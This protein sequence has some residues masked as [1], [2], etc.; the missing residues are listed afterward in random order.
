[1]SGRDWQAFDAELRARVPELAVELLGKPTFRAGQEWRWGRKGSLSVVIGGAKAGMWFDHQ[2]GRGGWFSDLVGRDLGMAREDATDWIADRIGMEALPRPAR[3]RSTPGATPAN[4]PGEP[5]TAPATAPPETIPDDDTASA[6]NRAVE[7]AVRATR[8]WSSGR[9]ALNDHPYLVAKHA[10]PLALRM[11]TSGRLV[12]PLQ[13][14]DGR[15]HSLEK[16]APDGAKRF[17]AGGAKKGHFAVVGAEPGPIA[18]PTGP[19]LICE[20]WA[21]GASLH[22]ATGHTVIAAM[23]AGNLMP[24]AEALRARFSVADLVLVAD[25]DKKPDR[26]TNPGVEVARKVALAVKGRLAV[27]D[28]PGDA[29]DLF[30]AE[31]PEAVAALVAGAAGIPP[32]PPTYPAPVLTPDVA[33][34][35][36][37]EAI[38]GFMAAIPDYWAAVEA[39]QE[40]AKNPD[41]D[42]DPLD[43]NIVARAALPPLLGLPVDV[44]LGKTS[45]ARTAIAELIAAGA[46]GKRKVV[47]A[48]P[49]HDLG[50]EQV[51]AFEALGVSA[52]LWKGRT[53]PDP[54]DDKPDRLMCLDTE[55][56]FDALEIER[57]RMRPLSCRGA[58]PSGL[59][60]RPMARCGW[61]RPG[62]PAGPGAHSS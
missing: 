52:M 44:G 49:R 51:A 25:N 56:T 21:T 31:G 7:A 30:C 19:I 1:M 9:P 13:D 62:R 48:V 60:S 45:S 26:D 12:V 17:L 23:D 5:P 22:I 40:E 39:A 2:E 4:D 58:R 29:N 8:I 33:R 47:Y 46:L 35:S 20:G 10:A 27:P 11:D 41:A 6:P 16:I 42:R 59:P 28:S 54:T 43:F 34:A 37:A 57:S 15:I 32:P 50:A 61:R 24:V 53:A 18:K 36:L 14:I 38:A 3:Q 55:A